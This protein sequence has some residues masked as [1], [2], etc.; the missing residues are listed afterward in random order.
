MPELERYAADPV[1]HVS[2]SITN[3][4]AGV[5]PIPGPYPLRPWRSSRWRLTVRWH[6]WHRHAAVQYSSP[7]SALLSSPFLFLRPLISL[8]AS[9][10]F[11]VLRSPRYLPLSLL[12]SSRPCPRPLPP[13]HAPRPV[14]QSQAA[15]FTTPYISSVKKTSSRCVTD[16]AKMSIDPKLIELTAGVLRMILT[17]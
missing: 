6:W 14:D 5:S 10:R 8:F 3:E 2:P 13:S 7:P 12:G 1:R 17:K 16:L 15:R 4:D 9:L 11:P